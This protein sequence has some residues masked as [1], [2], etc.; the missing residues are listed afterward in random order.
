VVAAAASFCLSC[1][2]RNLPLMM[3]RGDIQALGEP[4]SHK[5]H[6]REEGAMPMPH[7]CHLTIVLSRHGE[8]DRL[9]GT[10][11]WEHGSRRDIG[12]GPTD[13]P[14]ISDKANMEYL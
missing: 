13:L 12:I 10:R 7:Q 5:L 11:L 8:E 9:G 2:R 14:S 3:K 4:T 6:G 1:G